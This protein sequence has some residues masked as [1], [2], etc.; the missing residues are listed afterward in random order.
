[1]SPDDGR[2]LVSSHVVFLKYAATYMY[3]YMYMTWM[4]CSSVTCFPVLP[5][6]LAGIAGYQ[7]CV[8]KDPVTVL[9]VHPAP[10]LFSANSSF[11]NS[12]STGIE[13]GFT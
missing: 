7:T 4:K 6:H 8:R 2:Y 12:Y 10:R 11:F 1:M 5:W 3:M 13:D 9:V